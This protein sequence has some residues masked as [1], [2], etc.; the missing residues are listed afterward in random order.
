MPLPR[1]L[2]EEQARRRADEN[3]LAQRDA[4]RDYLRTALACVMWSAFGIFLVLWSFHTTDM[5]LG[6][7]AF[8][9]GLGIG[10]GGIIFTLLGAYRRGEKRG[11]W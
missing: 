4:I 9:A 1:H 3:E 5:T 6:K 7:A 11:D 8:S 10:N 2:L